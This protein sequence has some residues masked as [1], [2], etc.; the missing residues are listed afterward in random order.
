MKRIKPWNQWNVATWRR[1]LTCLSAIT[2]SAACAADTLPLDTPSEEG[3]PGADTSSAG[4]NGD[5]NTVKGGELKAAPRTTFRGE[6]YTSLGLATIVGDM[7]GD[8]YDDLMLLDNGGIDPGGTMARG[9]A[10]LIYGRETFP[11]TVDLAAA[12]LILRGASE[13]VSGLGDIDGDGYADVAFTTTC[14]TMVDHCSGT[15]GVHI[16]YGGAERMSGEMKS[17]EL[18]LH[19][20]NGGVKAMYTR[21]SRAG[22]VNG[23]GLDDMLIENAPGSEGPVTIHLLFG[24]SDR[25][26]QV[27]E[28]GFSDATFDG[29]DPDA[30]LLY[31]AS[32]PGDVD[33]DGYADLLIP[34]NHPDQVNATVGL[35]YGSPDRF[36]GSFVREDADATFEWRSNVATIGLGDLDDDGFADMGLPYNE[37]TSEAEFSGEL[38]VIYGKAERFSGTYDTSVVDFSLATSSGWVSGVG[39]GDINADGDLDLLI[40]DEVESVLTLLPGDSQRLHGHMQITAEQSH[41]SEPQTGGDNPS[42]GDDVASAGD[43]NGDG[44]DDMVVTAPGSVFGDEEG[45]RVYLYLGGEFE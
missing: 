9:A 40:G 34:A 6:P 14:F 44:V 41:I 24:R 39:S 30:H 33:N 5:D 2:I 12:D 45:G 15:Q 31:G 25:S 29:G 22:D 38:R 8:G 27:P 17:N 21:V 3:D 20:T 10:Y 11:K 42:L 37:Q 13:S 18:G 23:D 16:L 7:D 19:W 4:S 26:E 28:A 36:A 43:V 32:G 1:G 35:F